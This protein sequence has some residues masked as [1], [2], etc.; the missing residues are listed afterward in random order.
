MSKADFI[1]AADPVIW[2]SVNCPEWKPEDMAE[3]FLVWVRPMPGPERNSLEQWAIR[4]KNAI[5]K[6]PFAMKARVLKA[7][8]YDERDGQ[9][10][11]ADFSEED[12]AKLNP[13]AVDRVFE[14]AS[15]LSGITQKDVEEL[16][17]N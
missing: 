13:A 12:L 5:T 2:K 17:G 15:S 16:T 8:A 11:F 4:K 1:R 14:V 9:P 3:D 6:N 10:V 7:C